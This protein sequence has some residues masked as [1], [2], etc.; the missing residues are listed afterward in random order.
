MENESMTR[1]P[2]QQDISWFLD[3]NLKDQLDL[4][5]H[6]QRRSVWS[7]N[8][9]RFFIDTILNNYPAPQ[10]FLHKTTDDGGHSTYHVVDGKQRLNTIIEFTKDLISIPDYFGDANIRKRKWSE[11]DRSVHQ[12]FWNYV[13]TVEVLPDVSDASV[14]NIFER[15]NRNSRR[16]VPQELL[17]AKYEG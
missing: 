3:L 17:H 16:L 14:K 5:P 9:K 1:N 10:I 6:Y 7:S 8:D 2:T 4:D 11:L 12:R 13:L 15:I